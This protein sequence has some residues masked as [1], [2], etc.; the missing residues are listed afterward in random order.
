MFFEDPLANNK[1]PD[2][3]TAHDWLAYSGTEVST[4]YPL[5]NDNII[6]E[7]RDFNNNAQYSFPN[8]FN[9]KKK[10]NISM[11]L[12]YM[13]SIINLVKGTP[14][15]ELESS[16]FGK[17]YNPNTKRMVKKCAPGKTRNEK[18]RCVKPKAVRTMKKKRA[19]PTPSETAASF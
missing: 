19:K 9:I 11:K 14:L 17:E 8:E 10:Y 18:F 4:L 16:L 12:D 6:A 3:T 1:G 5:S 13:L 2:E 7:F 15:K